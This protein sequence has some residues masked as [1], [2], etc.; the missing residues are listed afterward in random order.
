MKILVVTPACHF[1]SRGAVQQDIYAMLSFFKKMGHDVAVFSLDQPG[2][3]PTVVQSIRDDYGVDVKVYLPALKFL[4]W[5]KTVLLQPIFFDRS[6]YAFHELANAPMFQNYLNEYKP[7]CLLS[8]GNYSWPLFAERKKRNIHFIIRS[9]NF[10]LLHYW[11]ELTA[12]E[13]CNPANWLRFLAKWGT[14]QRSVKVAD[15]IAAISPRETNQYNEWEAG[16]AALLPLVSLIKFT[17]YHKVNQDKKPL[18]L[19]FLGATYNV[20]FH[21]RGAEILITEI[22]QDIARRAPGEFRFHVCGGKLPVDLVKACNGEE[23]IY[24]GFVPDLEK[25]FSAMDAGVF[26]VWSGRGMKQKIFESIARGFPIVVPKISL[27]EYPLVHNESALIAG[28]SEEMIEMILQLRDPKV[29]ERLSNGATEFSREWFGEE[30]FK[31][32]FSKIIAYE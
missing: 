1:P 25:F 3:D 10:E 26:P 2:Q 31:D 32:F 11:E 29:R 14:E 27:G 15:K 12:K 18:D 24:E 22:A 17:A 28:R 4:S 13:K 16:K 21:R 5:L 20:P 6:A 30:K 7:D 8:I 9:H 23:V 19:F